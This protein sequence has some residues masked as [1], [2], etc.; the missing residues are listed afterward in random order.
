LAVVIAAEADVVSIP[1]FAIVCENRASE[2]VLVPPAAMSVML[3][4]F[5]S[6]EVGWREAL[7]VA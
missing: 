5:V 3:P 7:F 4:P 1:V 6:A 2:A